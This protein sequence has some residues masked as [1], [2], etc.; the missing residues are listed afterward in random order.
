VVVLTVGVIAGLDLA[1]VSWLEELV[2]NLRPRSAP[3]LDAGATTP[4]LVFTRAEAL[5]EEAR[6]DGSSGGFDR[7]LDGNALDGGAVALDAGSVDGSRPVLGAGVV[8]A[9]RADGGADGGR[10]GGDDEVRAAAESPDRALLL[11]VR[12]TLERSEPLS[13]RHFD[14]LRTLARRERGDPVVHT[15]LAR[16]MSARGWSSDAIERYQ[17]AYEIDSDVGNDRAV[18]DDLVRLAAHP[19][20]GHRAVRALE[21]IAGRRAAPL[22]RRALRDPDLSP[23]ERARL[24]RALVRLRSP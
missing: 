14:A 24:E 12:E 20:L 6:V 23:A 4:D 2:S 21:R 13:Q 9:D 19:R 16:A 15:L 7:A 17:L 3:I 11:H 10:D 8:D 22:V 5:E 18:L 1:G